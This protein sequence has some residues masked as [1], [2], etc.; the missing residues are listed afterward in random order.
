LIER[1]VYSLKVGGYFCIGWINY[2]WET[3]LHQLF[4]EEFNKL[5]ESVA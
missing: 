5:P 2:H 1:C 4:A 3:E